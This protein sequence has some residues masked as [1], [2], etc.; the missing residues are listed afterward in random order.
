MKPSSIF[1]ILD[2]EYHL[3]FALIIC[4]PLSPL[5]EHKPEHSFSDGP[6]PAKR[7]VSI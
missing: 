4:S 5:A 1:L 7:R 6:T 3:S 2:P